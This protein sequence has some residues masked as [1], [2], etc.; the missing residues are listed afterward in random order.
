MER[1]PHAERRYAPPAEAVRDCGHGPRSRRR[2]G[3]RQGWA[4]E[5]AGGSR[6]ATSRGPG[7]D[8][9]AAGAG[10][11]A[12]ASALHFFRDDVRLARFDAVDPLDPVEHQAGQLAQ[13]LRFAEGKDVGPTPA[14]V[15]RLDAW[16]L[17][18]LAENGESGTGP[19]IAEDERLN[20]H[21]ILLVCGLGE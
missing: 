10:S 9:A 18:H 11:I 5:R 2:Q 14:R 15:G 6:Q 8:R 13:P 1:K 7:A 16:D 4:R 12:E 19:G 17:L 21:G 3:S 20:G